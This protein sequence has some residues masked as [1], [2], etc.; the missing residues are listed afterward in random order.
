MP[1]ISVHS[2]HR[3]I[4][5]RKLQ[6]SDSFYIES[7]PCL[8]KVLNLCVPV[9]H[10]LGSGVRTL[11]FASLLSVTQLTNS[12]EGNKLYCCK[13]MRNNKFMQFILNQYFP[14]HIMMK[15]YFSPG[16]IRNRKSSS[17][18]LSTNPCGFENIIW[19]GEVG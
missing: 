15:S 2:T 5:K 19:S 10:A 18:I 12:A 7:L 8:D 13:Q 14:S 4:I 1:L 11:K 3:S 9:R 6:Y 16:L 17:A